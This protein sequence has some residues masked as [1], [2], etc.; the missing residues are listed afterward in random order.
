M[1]GIQHTWLWQCS[2]KRVDGEQL[3]V[4]TIIE[5]RPLMIVKAIAKQQIKLRVFC[6]WTKSLR[7]RR[8]RE[9]FAE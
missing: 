6:S 8:K 5:A 4:A 9:I 7:I 3:V 2:A 1:E